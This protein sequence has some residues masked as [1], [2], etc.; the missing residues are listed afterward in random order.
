MLRVENLSKIYSNG[1]QALKNVSFK[2]D[3]GEFVVVLGKSGSGKSTLFR[4]LNRLVEPTEGR[5]FFNDQEI[6]GAN[7]KS[8]RVC[9]RKMGFIFQQFNL[10]H[11]CSVMTNVLMGRLGYTPSWMG[12]IGYFF[13]KDRAQ[14]WE[15]LQRLEM[16]DKAWHRSGDLSGGQQQRVGIARALMQKPT[17]ILADE[18]IAS[19]DPGLAR[20]IMETLKKINENDGVTI[21][22]NLHQPDLAIEYGKRVLVLKSGQFIFDG[23]SESLR[24]LETKNIY[25]LKD[26]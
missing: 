17:V 7:R 3:P 20:S 9:R 10:I 19:L 14:A 12:L 22:C 11:R 18:P 8:I 15:I 24:K 23:S 13:K 16:D 21:L 25:N 1:T 26:Q 5:I 2:I 6:T 4:C